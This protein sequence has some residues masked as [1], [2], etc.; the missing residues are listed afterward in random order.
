MTILLNKR[1][2]KVRLNAS[3]TKTNFLENIEES[4]KKVEWIKQPLWKTK[5]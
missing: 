1:A 3:Y 2:V 5:L 4:I